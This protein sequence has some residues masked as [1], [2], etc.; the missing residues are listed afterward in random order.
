MFYFGRILLICYLKSISHFLVKEVKS[1][2]F[3]RTI[4]E[5]L[6]I[7]SYTSKHCISIYAVRCALHVSF[8]FLVLKMYLHGI[9]IIYNFLILNHKSFQDD[10]S[11]R[12]QSSE[13]KIV[14]LRQGSGKD[15][16]EMA[17]KAK[18]LKA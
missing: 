10:V 6:I 14:K 16:Q 7:W 11:P 5:Q 15:G 18:G 1:F 9:Y 3:K 17:L 8:N 2:H 13:T 4:E 12:L